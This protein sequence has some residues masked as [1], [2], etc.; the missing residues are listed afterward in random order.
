MSGLEAGVLAGL[1]LIGGMVSGMLGIGGAVL[2]IPLLLY[3][4]PLFGIPAL[5]MSQI[6]GITLAQVLA[7]SLSGVSAHRR[8]GNFDAHLVLRLGIPIVAGSLLGALGSHWLPEPLL[9]ASYGLVA[10]FAAYLLVRPKKP[11]ADTTPEY[12]GHVPPIAGLASFAVG[13]LAGMVGVGGAFILLP[14]MVSWLHVPMRLAVGSSL[15]IVLLSSLAGLVGKLATH[16]IA[17]KPALLVVA[18]AIIGAQF[19]SRLS[20]RIPVTALRL[21]LAAVL[22]VVAGRVGL[23]LVR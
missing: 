9:K 19:G 8:A 14:L 2:V 6:T 23:D 10:L 17:G 4:P 7:A 16:Q 12:L 18:G 22:V 3:V 15:G 21:G 1:G 13:I 20:N 11:T 5:P